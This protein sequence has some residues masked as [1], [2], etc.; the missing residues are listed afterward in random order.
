MKRLKGNRVILKVENDHERNKKASSFEFE[1][2]A[3]VLARIELTS[4]V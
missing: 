3:V 4:K 2:F 1:A